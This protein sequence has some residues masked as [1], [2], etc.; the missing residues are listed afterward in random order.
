MKLISDYKNNNLKNLEDTLKQ[1]KEKSKAVQEELNKLLQLNE[2]LE[3]EYLY[4]NA[5]ER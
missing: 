2:N 5:F 4:G 1:G 3:M